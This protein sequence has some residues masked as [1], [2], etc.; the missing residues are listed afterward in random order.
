ME[1]RLDYFQKNISKIVN[2]EELDTLAQHG[3]YDLFEKDIQEIAKQMHTH[4]LFKDI[5]NV[6]HEF[7]ICENYDFSLSRDEVA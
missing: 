6:R 4:I 1:N 2:L 5:Y 3:D 7:G